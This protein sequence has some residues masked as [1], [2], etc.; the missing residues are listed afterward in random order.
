MEFKD[1][2]DI[3]GV[4]RDATLDE[5]KRSYRKLARKYHPDVSQEVDA[6]AKF[7][8]VG[9]AYEV[10]KDPEKRAAYD[11]LGSQWQAGQDFHP[12]PGW[13]AGFEFSGG[14]RETG[15]PDLDAFSDFFASLYGRDHS[16]GRASSARSPGGYQVR[17]EDHHAKVMVDL[18]DSYTGATRSITL[19]IPELTADGHVTTRPRTLKV[20]IPK[21]IHQGQQIRL[22]GQGGAGYGGGE[23]GD[24]YLEMEFSPNGQYRVEGADVYLDLPLAP[25]EAAL[26]ATVK[27]PTPSGAIDLKV[28]PNSQAGKKL[29]LKGRGIPARKAGDLYVV[30]QIALP[31]A[32]SEEHRRIYQQMKQEFTFNPRAS[33]EA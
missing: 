11:Q 33:L 28:P 15:G 17:G 3:M 27:V 29:R 18:E 20:R 1:Y 26:G 30:L 19:Q 31:P 4:K 9:E 5:L 24:L 21:G 32:D 13:D 22:A 2:Y 23:A 8:E 12:P 16:R 6:E 25:W 10:L 7:K 14:G